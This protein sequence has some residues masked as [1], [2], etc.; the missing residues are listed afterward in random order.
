MP[1]GCTLTGLTIAMRLSAEGQSVLFLYG[2]EWTSTGQSNFIVES[3][4][5]SNSTTGTF[6]L[7]KNSTSTGKNATRVSGTSSAVSEWLPAESPSKTVVGLRGRTTSGNALNQCWK[8]GE[9][10][11]TLTSSLGATADFSNQVHYI[12]ARNQAQY[13][14]KGTMTSLICVYKECTD[15]EVKAMSRYI[16]NRMGGVY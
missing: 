12:G 9:V 14:Y 15:T 2:G 5:L 16:N 8:N 7:V 4:P 3:S 11:G 6:Y 13:F 10:L 1:M